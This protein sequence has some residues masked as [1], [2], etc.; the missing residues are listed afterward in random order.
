LLDLVDGSLKDARYLTPDREPLFLSTLL[1][2]AG[3]KPV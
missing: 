1:K 2:N 3:V